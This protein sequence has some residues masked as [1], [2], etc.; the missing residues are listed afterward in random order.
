MSKPI[1]Q[2]GKMVCPRC[3]LA[4]DILAY[5][6]LQLYGDYACAAIYKCPNCR[7]VFAPLPSLFDVVSNQ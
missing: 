6:A 1:I 5:K 4:Q 2:D 7:A 3:E